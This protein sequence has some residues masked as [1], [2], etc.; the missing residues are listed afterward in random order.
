MSTMSRI[1]KDLSI[2]NHRMYASEV[3]RY[4]IR[5][6]CVECPTYYIL[7]SGLNR[8]KCPRCDH[9]M[10]PHQQAESV[11]WVDNWLNIFCVCEYCK[12]RCSVYA[13]L[14]MNW[15]R[16]WM[17]MPHTVSMSEVRVVNS[18]NVVTRRAT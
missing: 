5:L 1:C 14:E 18:R 6:F 4:R 8:I 16:L 15:I 13:M 2:P 7:S 12:L 17:E 10:D 11:I 9:N 3:E